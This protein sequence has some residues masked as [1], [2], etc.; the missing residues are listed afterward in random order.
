MS[1]ELQIGPRCV[2]LILCDQVI[3]DART[4]KKSLVG[5]FNNA[6]IP[7]PVGQPQQVQVLR[8][9]VFAQVTNL[10]RI[11]P[12]NL[13]IGKPDGTDVIKM[14]LLPRSVKQADPLTVYEFVFEI[15]VLPVE[16]Q[17][18]YPVELLDEAGKVLGSTKFQA[19]FAVEHSLTEA[20]RA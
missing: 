13:R 1:T 16:Q 4:G 6:N 17:G 9:F 19:S 15:P 10:T 2:A 7:V 11:V 3:L 14:G 18:L 5:L 12:F 20:P 8:M